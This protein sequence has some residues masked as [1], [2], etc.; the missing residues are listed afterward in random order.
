MPQLRTYLSLLLF[1]IFF[2]EG[3][4]QITVDF[5]YSD[6]IGCD[7]LSVNFLD[8]SSS[9]DGDIT[10]WEW[11]I[12]FNTNAQN[13]SRTYGSPG[14]YTVCLTVTDEASNTETLCKN[15][16]IKVYQGP[17]AGIAA[18]MPL[19]C[20]PL[21]VNFMDQSVAGDAAIN[22]WEWGLSGNCGNV[23]GTAV[24]C[25]YNQADNYAIILTVTDD[26]GCTNTIT[27]TDFVQV[28]PAPLIDVTAIDTFACAPPLSPTFTN[29]IPDPDVT[30]FWDFGPGMPTFEG[31]NPPPGSVTYMQPGSFPVTVIATNN[32][33][34][35]KDT[36]VLENFINIGF[37]VEF[38]ASVESG[39]EDLSVTF[40][41][42]S[43]EPATEVM[44]DFGN[45]DSSTDPN[46]SYTYQVPGCYTVSLTRNAGGCPS[47]GFYSTCI[48]VDPVP[49]VF[50]SN[51]NN[52]GC[53]L[54]HT[55]NFA[56]FSTSAVSWSWDFGDGNTSTEQNPVHLFEDFG[57]Y[58]VE[59]TVTNAEGCT[60]SVIV[61]TIEVSQ[62]QAILVNDEIE[63]C[64]P[65]QVSLEEN[66]ASVTDI[67]E[68]LWEIR[69]KDGLVAYTSM[70]ENPV[71]EI[72]DTGI[73]DV[74][75]I[76]ENTLGCTDTTSF[77]ESISVGQLPVVNFSSDLV[78]ACIE[79]DITFTDESSPFAEEWFWDFGD[80]QNSSEQ[81]P[82]HFYTDT[83]FYDI[84][85]VTFHNGCVNTLTLDDYIHVM[86]PVSKFNVL[87]FC[88]EPGKRRFQNQSI[89]ADSVFWDFGV[90]GT[91]TDTTSANNPEFFYTTP[92]TYTVLQTVFNSE[93][94]C[95]H[96]SSQEL[97]ITNPQAAFDVPSVEGCAP[98]T[99]S[100]IDASV[101]AS[102]WKWDAPGGVITDIGAQTPT[103]TYNVPGKYTDIQLII[104][105]V[106]S[107]SDTIVFTDTI[108]VNG[109][110]VNFDANPLVGCFPLEVNFTESSTSLFGTPDQWEWT[111]G[112]NLGTSIDQNPSFIF[113]TTGLFDIRLKVTDD[114]GCVKV[115]KI[116]DMIEV[117]RPV[118]DF[119]AVTLGCTWDSIAFADSSMGQV[120]T[121]LWDFGDGETSTDQ[122]PNHLYD[123]NGSYEICLTVTDIYDCDSTLCKP[124]YV[125]IADPVASFTVDSTF[126]SCPPLPVNFTNES[127]NTTS[128]L[129]DYGDESGVS[130]IEDPSHTYTIPGQY[131]VT[132]ISSSTE[133]C[134]DT[135]VVQDLIVLDGPEGEY[136]VD[137][138]TSCAPATITFIGTSL[139]FYSY[140]W[141][142]GTGVLVESTE[143]DTLQVVSFTYE[144][145]GVY[146]PALTFVNSTGCERT[147]PL[148]DPIHVVSSTPDFTSSQTLFCGEGGNI[149]FFNTSTSAFGDPI[150]G[151]EWIF[152]GGDPMTSTSFEP[153][154]SYENPGKFDV[155]LIAFN[156]GCFDTLTREEYIVVAA[157]PN[158]G[159]SMSSSTGC[160]PFTISFTDISTVVGGSIVEWFWDFG[161]GTN[162]T[163][164]N[165]TH[166]YNDGNDYDVTLTVTSSDGCSSTTV[167]PITVFPLAEISAG[168]DRDICM[169]ERTQLEGI[170][171]GDTTGVSYWWSPTNTLSCVNCLNPIANPL[172]TTIYSFMV[173]SPE[174]CIA[175][176]EVTVNVK[177]FPVPVIELTEDTTICANA[178]IQLEVSGGD[179]VF[180]YQWNEADDGL[181]CYAS[182]FNPIASP[183]ETT[184]YNVTV[185]NM[186]GCSSQDSV[187]VGIVDQFQPFAG[188]DRIICSG[189]TIQLNT[190]FGINPIWLVNS[191]LSCTE[192]PDPMAQPLDT[193]QYIVKVT[194]ADLGCEVM[195]TL[196][197]FVVDEDDIDVG[198]DTTIC[199]G[200]ATTLNGGGVGTVTWTPGGSLD[201]DA[202]LNPEAF[203]AESTVYTMSLENG[204][205]ILKDSVAINVRDKA[206]ITASDVII[207]YG[208]T[209]SLQARGAADTYSWTSQGTDPVDPNDSNPRVSPIETTT[210]MV[211]GSLASCDSDTAFVTVEVLPAPNV[212]LPPLYRFFTDQIV[213]LKPV[214]HNEMEGPNYDFSWSPSD[215]LDCDDCREPIWDPQRER[216]AFTLKITNRETGCE[217]TLET[218]AQFIESCPEDLIAVP[219]V[220]SPNGDGINDELEIFISP[221]VRQ[222]TYMR[223]FDRWGGQV[224]EATGMN[225][226]PWDGKNKGIDVPVGVYIYILEAPCEATGRSF[227][228]SGDITIMR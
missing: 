138:D 159:F 98:F 165:P 33:S 210:Y 86:A 114:K 30:L 131:S 183:V 76:V 157:N 56:G 179:N 170:I 153:S 147:L 8:L 10:A 105:D 187:E 11:D 2:T 96:R 14:F 19:G 205:C 198:L 13:P 148:I 118:A 194:T 59:L 67:D 149:D 44:W 227:Q 40:T 26:N 75:L 221:A 222:I 63:G 58:P 82:V 64:I 129:W 41:D 220:F 4:S 60:N 62:L 201:N 5:T 85:L 169:G 173:Q 95:F 144:N 197:I 143:S 160:A 88:D 135:V 80:G 128:F 103:I 161:D 185:T 137:V 61:N 48:N 171:F 141:D 25:T 208:E 132:L 212:T 68:W 219:N 203:P 126:A 1:A 174:G 35:C 123:N 211:I 28:T 87:N 207:C 9:T 99:P 176:S 133:T 94:G 190:D 223:I 217:A 130:T 37:P 31:N 113:D 216:Q 225:E 70:D 202:V 38:S 115:K 46:P 145:P 36:L 163:L 93:T 55:V 142:F 111:F 224:F 228:K 177:P 106:N 121:Y 200:D 167:N 120:L 150:I 49:D 189:S 22:N 65:M 47:V 39:C 191:G 206:A 151:V 101:D 193:T 17:I 215:E 124:N 139:D 164:S 20:V 175:T 57:M 81:N 140:T 181:S 51:L 182:C 66:S 78:E 74:V 54:P 79:W 180:S 92:G 127:L 100:V 3:T 117:T 134:S 6:S 15:D 172:D 24:S 102:A 162:S 53:S 146:Q 104:T 195:D 218:V 119:S 12:G 43:S 90:L 156:G 184:L 192:C 136:S 213:H 209:V 73:Y 110:T 178:V 45:G 18:D 16:V 186:F 7:F 196:T 109:V 154:V 71:F 23:T 97:I 107:C 69:D 50:Y 116:S 108:F 112:D 32:N 84:S 83:G 122:N 226:K 155:T 158:T 214:I 166:I 204:E 168:E 77:E 89:D 91:D 72:S 21:E 125:I 34:Q 42:L 188:E 152:E 29:L 52:I 27:E 199:L